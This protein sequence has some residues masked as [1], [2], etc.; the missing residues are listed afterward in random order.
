MTI[1]AFMINHLKVL[2]QEFDITVICDKQIDFKKEYNLNI[3][4]KQ[5]FIHRK[6]NIFNDIKSFFQVFNF[7]RQNKFDIVL[8]VTPKAG[9]I[10]MVASYI[11]LVKIR[12]HFFTGQVWAT[13]KGVFRLLLKIID[14]ITSCVSTDILVDSPSQRE[15]I[16]SEN[17]VNEQKSHFLHKGSISGVDLKKFTKDENLREIYRKK[18]NISNE[19]V[20]LFLG[21]L[22]ID[23]GI[24]DLATVFNELLDKYDDI[25]LLLIGPD[26][27]NIEERI[28]YI[29]NKKNVFRVGYVS[30]PQEILNMADVLVLPSYREGFGTIVIESAAMKIPTIGSNIYG[31]NDAI[32]DNST[33][34]LHKKGD[35]YDMKNKYEKIILNRDLIKVFGDN[36]YNRVIDDFTSDILS[37]A[38][39]DF[40]IKEKRL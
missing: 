23:K 33:G 2:S 40:L 37:H 13:K 29:L 25:K 21:R 39:L 15:F 6:I 19:L 5:I 7:L 31:L 38:L 8:T 16:I 14:K 9:L 1:K 35:L 10:G 28:S 11:T 32:V 26:E 12:I 34:L 3:T 27:A 30:N 24:L 20:F 17:I 18:Y 36:A 22:N 4:F